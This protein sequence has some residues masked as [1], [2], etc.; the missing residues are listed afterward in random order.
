MTHWGDKVVISIVL[1]SPET[2]IPVWGSWATVHCEFV[3]S[4]WGNGRQLQTLSAL[5]HGGATDGTAVSFFVKSR[6][7][8]RRYLQLLSSW[9]HGGPTEGTCSYF[10][11]EI[12]VDQQKVP[13]VTFFLKSRWTKR[14]YMQLLSSSNHGWTTEGTCSYFQ[15][16]RKVPAQLLSSVFP[17]RNGAFPQSLFPSTCITLFTQLYFLGTRGEYIIHTCDPYICTEYDIIVHNPCELLPLIWVSRLLT[18]TS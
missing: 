3:K 6:W 9:N 7:A 5:N 2:F 4:W 16:Q 18:M 15:R 12:T 14:R 13:A 8:N 11:P 1:L 17:P 10:L